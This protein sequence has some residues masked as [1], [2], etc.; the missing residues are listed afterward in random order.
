MPKVQLIEYTCVFED[1]D[2]SSLT[3]CSC[4]KK[5]SSTEEIF[6]VGLVLENPTM[7][8]SE[9]CEELKDTLNVDISVSTICKTLRRYGVTRKKIRQVASQRCYAL[10][11][12]FLSQCFLLH[13]AMFVWVDET[14]TDSRD[15]IRKFGYS[16][17]GT[18]PVSRRFLSRGKRINV[19]AALSLTGGIIAT[20]MMNT[21]VNGDADTSNDAI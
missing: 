20:K 11:G 1:V 5:L 14:G 21:S 18:T 3:I 7:Y 10:H 15:N 6:V 8:I 16:L 2:S 9:V 4:R 13:P 12:V 19:V 17:R